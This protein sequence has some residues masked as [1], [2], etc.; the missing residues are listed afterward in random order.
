MRMKVYGNLLGIVIMV[1]FFVSGCGGLGGF[2]EEDILPISTSWHWQL[3]GS[4]D[5]DLN[6][7][8][9]DIDLFETNTSFIES[10]HQKGKIVVCYFSAGSY[11]SW[12]PDASEYSDKIIGEKV[13]GWPRE[14]WVD[15]RHDELRAIIVARLDLAKKKG[16]DGIEPDNVD[17][18]LHETGFNFD[19]ADQIDF[20]RFLADESHRRGLIVG[21]KNDLA[22]IPQLVDYFDFALNESCHRYHECDL[23]QPFIDAGKPV[24]N[25]EY[26]QKYVDD[27]E[28]RAAL[29]ADARARSFQT[30]VLPK[31]LDGSFRYSCNDEF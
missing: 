30:L 21:L 22:Q 16:C 2:S 6:V 1:M 17:G 28:E 7:A 8:L 12:R 9:Y 23:L 5:P 10:L 13:D 27:P 15:I 31:A 3:Q 11:E 20:N 25:A 14:R 4:I 24:F 26:S 18:Y 29:C 19:A